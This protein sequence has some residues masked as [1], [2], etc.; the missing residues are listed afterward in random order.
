[1]IGFQFSGTS[2]ARLRDVHP[3]LQKV[4]R[5]AL[6]LSK[7]DFS[8]AEGVR[9]YARQKELFDSGKSRTMNSR[10]LTGHAVDLYPVH[11]SGG[12]YQREDF[13]EL[14]DAMRR[15]SAALGIPVE[16]GGDWKSFTDCP[17]WQLPVRA[18]P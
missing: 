11:K 6:E 8:V 15:A 3:D 17:H 14:A 13:T 9:S 7:T 4:V 10:H 16:W 2:E 1:M 5:R 12:E 18:Y